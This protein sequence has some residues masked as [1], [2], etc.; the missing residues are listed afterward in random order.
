MFPS[1]LSLH[2]S[3]GGFDYVLAPLV[4][5]FRSLCNVIYSRY[6]PS[7]VEGNGSETQVL[8]VSGSDLVLS[9]SQ[10]SSHVVGMIASSY[11]LCCEWI[12]K[13]H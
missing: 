12:L 5:S 3:T 1:L 4:L 10:W 7:L 9:P 11:F 8:P 6:R 13:P 2:I